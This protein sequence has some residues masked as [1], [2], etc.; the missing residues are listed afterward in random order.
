MSRW[1]AGVIVERRDGQRDWLVD[2]QLDGLA[3]GK[4][5]GQIVGWTEEGTDLWMERQRN[6]RKKGGTHWRTDF[7]IDTQMSGQMDG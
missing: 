3:D 4:K 6:W 1:L 7:W 2:R 5:K